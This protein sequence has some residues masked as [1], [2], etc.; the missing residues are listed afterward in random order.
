MGG[1]SRGSGWRCVHSHTAHG[2]YGYTLFR[3]GVV[4]S[5]RLVRLVDAGDEAFL[6]DWVLKQRVQGQRTLFF[7]PT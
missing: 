6:I 2:P 5:V 1:E 7:F 4:V 3:N